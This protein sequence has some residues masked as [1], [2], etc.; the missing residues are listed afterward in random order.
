MLASL[1]SVAAFLALS[2]GIAF[3][4]WSDCGPEKGDSAVFINSLFDIFECGREGRT[5]ERE[6]GSPSRSTRA[7]STARQTDTLR[8]LVS[9][10]Q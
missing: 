5:E 3:L 2:A 10:A 4:L 1:G 6:A 8:S 7:S 9:T